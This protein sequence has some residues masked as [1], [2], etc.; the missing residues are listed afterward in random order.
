MS[1]KE[2]FAYAA[3]QMLITLLFNLCL[4]SKFNLQFIFIRSLCSS[5]NLLIASYFSNQSRYF[6]ALYF[7]S[8]SS[9]TLL[10]TKSCS[11]DA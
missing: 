11:S 2:L 10:L 8:D 5:S 3:L 1:F 4:H 6:Q 7:C 9:T